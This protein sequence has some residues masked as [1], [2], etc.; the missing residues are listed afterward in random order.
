MGGQENGVKNM[1]EIGLEERK[2]M[3]GGCQGCNH[4]PQ[5]LI[6]AS[7]SSRFGWLMKI[8]FA[9]RHSCLICRGKGCGVLAGL[10]K[11]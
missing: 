11:I 1:M 7:N 3:G 5:I 6:G 2:G 8:S 4:S 10:R 9:V